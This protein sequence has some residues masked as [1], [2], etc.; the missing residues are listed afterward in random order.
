MD[1]YHPAWRGSATTGGSAWPVRPRIPPETDPRTRGRASRTP[2]SRSNPD[3][4]MRPFQPTLARPERPGGSAARPFPGWRSGGP[5][6]QRSVDSAGDARNRSGHNPY[7]SQRR[8]MI[9]GDRAFVQ[10][11]DDRFAGNPSSRFIFSPLSCS[12]S[13]IAPTVSPA[14]LPMQGASDPFRQTRRHSS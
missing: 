3:R 5:P 6:T 9:P 11:I 4:S 8:G 7:N 10:R 1:R 12:D 13:E 14:R 2:C